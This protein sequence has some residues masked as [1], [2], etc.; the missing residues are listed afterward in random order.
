MG[1]RAAW[2]LVLAHPDIFAG[3]IISSGATFLQAYQMQPLLGVSIRNYFGD[4]DESGLSLASNN[5]QANYVGRLS[6]ERQH[7]PSPGEC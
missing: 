5:T 2:N 6:A 4:D 7:V 3:V 1:A